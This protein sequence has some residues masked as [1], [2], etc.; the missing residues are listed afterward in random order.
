MLA[1]GIYL[2]VAPESADALWP[3]DLTPA[4]GQGDRR[5]RRGL[6]RLGAARGRSPTTCRSFEGAALAYAA[7]GAARAGRGRALH[8]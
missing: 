8:G 6:R 4:D 1:I 7:L 2:F 5:V 3:W